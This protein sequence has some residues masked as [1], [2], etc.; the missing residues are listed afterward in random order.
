MLQNNSDPLATSI[1]I[2]AKFILK[3]KKSKDRS[4]AYGLLQLLESLIGCV[5]PFPHYILF[6]NSVRGLAKAL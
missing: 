3:I 5:R 2:N 1:R 6:S 4:L